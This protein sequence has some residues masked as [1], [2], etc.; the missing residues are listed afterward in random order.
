MN[1][2]PCA[3]CATNFMRKTNDPEAPKLC[4]NCLVREEIRNPSKIKKVETMD[5]LI[6]CP[7]EIQAEIEEYCINQGIDFSKYFISLHQTSMD[8]KKINKEVEEVKKQV[9]KEMFE[10]PR[11]KGKKK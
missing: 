1:P 2:I 8:R 9:D 5:I 11:T 3:H 10:T 7:I 4:N 6:K